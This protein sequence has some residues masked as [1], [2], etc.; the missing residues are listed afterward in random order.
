MKNRCFKE[1]PFRSILELQDKNEKNGTLSTELNL[2][3]IQE[4]DL[5]H[6][7]STFE[8]VL[9]SDRLKYDLNFF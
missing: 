4:E 8:E 6:K 9:Q 7:I 5:A 3:Q 1:L 2:G